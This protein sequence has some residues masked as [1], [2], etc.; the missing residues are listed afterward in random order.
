MTFSTSNQWLEAAREKARNK[1]CR[2]DSVEDEH[3]AKASVFFDGSFMVR[4]T[5]SSASGFEVTWS[6]AGPDGSIAHVVAGEESSRLEAA[7][8]EAVKAF[9]RLR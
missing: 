6:V 3:G 2:V 7:K 1:L 4:S 9:W 8:S 5:A